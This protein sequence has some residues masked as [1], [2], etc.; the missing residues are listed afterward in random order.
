MA[1]RDVPLSSLMQEALDAQRPHLDEGRVEF[2][3]A[4]PEWQPIVVYQAGEQMVVTS[5]HHRVEAAR[6]LG[7]STIRAEVHVVDNIHE[8][9][10]FPDQ[11]PRLP[12]GRIE[13]PGPTEP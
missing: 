4:T 12:W 2:Y 1:I 6:Q 8:A 5:G 9:T 13:L 11:G 10:R 3:V 7:L